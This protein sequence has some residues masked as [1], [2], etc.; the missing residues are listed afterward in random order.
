MDSNR[1]EMLLLNFE[2]INFHCYTVTTYW[3]L[4]RTE[5]SLMSLLP[6]V[7]FLLCSKRTV[8][9]G[10]VAEISKTDILK[11]VQIKTTAYARSDITDANEKRCFSF[12]NL[13]EPT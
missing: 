2:F 5:S 11:S 4:T 3:D 1:K 9:V 10:E 8:C 6:S 12:H 13:G 7:L